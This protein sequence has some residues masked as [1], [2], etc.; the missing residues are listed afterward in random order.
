MLDA[1]ALRTE[2]PERSAYGIV[3]ISLFG[4]VSTPYPKL[5]HIERLRQF[6]LMTRVPVFQV[7]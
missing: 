4:V 2:G 5:D 7:V 3:P 6:S 1:F